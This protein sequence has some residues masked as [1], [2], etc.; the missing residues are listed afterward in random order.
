MNSPNYRIDV[1]QGLT[2]VVVRYLFL[3][4]IALSMESQS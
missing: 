2:K 1:N 4:L 3:E